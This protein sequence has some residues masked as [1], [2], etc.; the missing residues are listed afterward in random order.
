MGL[1]VIC[2]AVLVTIGLPKMFGEKAPTTD[3]QVVP[4]AVEVASKTAALA[5]E[6]G[7]DNA[8]LMQDS[9]AIDT[10]AAVHAPC[11]NFAAH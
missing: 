3:V 4:P 2:T 5:P 11:P 1:F 6:S 9:S 8:L 10:G 7:S